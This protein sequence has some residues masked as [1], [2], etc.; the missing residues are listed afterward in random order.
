MAGM[1]DATA[2]KALVRLIL[3]CANR[4]LNRS[5][6]RALRPARPAVLSGALTDLALS[7]AELIAQNALL[8]LCWLGDAIQ[9][10]LGPG[11]LPKPVN[12]GARSLI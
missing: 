7:Q 4:L 5:V 6:K 11:L 10:S 2:V 3:S 1:L 9:A 12:L 8:R